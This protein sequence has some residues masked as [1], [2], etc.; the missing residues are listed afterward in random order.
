MK[1]A[2][3][4]P[5]WDTL[6]G[7]ERYAI[8]FAK[9]LSELNYS[10]DIEWN[11]NMLLNDIEKRFGIETSKF[12]IVTDIRKGDGY[13]V[14]FWISDG[15]IPLLHSRNNILHF[16]VPFVNVKGDSLLNR[17]KLFRIKHILC[18]SVFTKN[19][20]DGEYKVDSQVIYPP[21]DTSK[22]KPKR[23]ENIILS[24]GRFSQL[25]Q[26]KHQ[27]ILI[28]VFKSLCKTGIKDWRLVLAGGTDIGGK[29][30]FEYLKSLADGFPIDFL[31][32]P[33]YRTIV[34]LFGRAKIFWSA[35]GY[36]VNEEKYPKRVEHFGITVVEAIAGGC[37][38]LI[39]NAGGHREIVNDNKSLLW[40]KK[41]ELIN[42]TA[43]MISEPKYLKNMLSTIPDVVK[44]Y[45]YERFKKEVELLI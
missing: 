22:I 23:K 2:I 37:V 14:C 9:V 32:S 42:H 31:D 10:V 27:D 7:G 30:Y 17:M 6:G 41:S 3:Y 28:E 40:N 1:A 15:S 45:S 11:D 38:P 25:L 43:K 39:Y 8:S 5:Y 34:D 36:G 20:I 44:N 29:K 16:Q 19:R 18:N 12:K 13:D 26:S 33:D 21:C 35:S 24:I 4:N